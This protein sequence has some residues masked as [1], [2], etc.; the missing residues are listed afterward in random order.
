[1]QQSFNSQIISGKHPGLLHKPRDATALQMSIQSIIS[2]VQRPR[3]AACALAFL[4]LAVKVVS[5]PRAFFWPGAGSDRQ[6][7]AALPEGSLGCPFVGE[8]SNFC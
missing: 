4:L 7:K 8:F 1:M 6:C 2:T 3:I 5:D